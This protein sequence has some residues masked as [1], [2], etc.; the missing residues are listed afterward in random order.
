MST[1]IH[2]IPE[3]S[4]QP[5]IPSNLLTATATRIAPTTHH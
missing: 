1:T 2:T 3:Y 4:H 5:L